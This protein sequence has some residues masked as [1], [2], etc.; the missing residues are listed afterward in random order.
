MREGIP[1]TPTEKGK[2][3]KLRSGTIESGERRKQGADSKP[4]VL[5]PYNG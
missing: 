5:G 2:R 1:P 3:E 4:R